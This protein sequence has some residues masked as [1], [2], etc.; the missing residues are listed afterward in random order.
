MKRILI[1]A[2]MAGSMLAAEAAYAASAT[3]DLAVS[4]E[5]TAFCEVKSG[6]TLTFTPT[7][8]W[9]NA[10]VDNTGSFNVQCTNGTPYQIGL[11]DGLHASGGVRRMNFGTEHLNYQLFTDSYG[12]TAWGNANG[13]TTKQSQTGDGDVQQHDVYGRVPSGQTAPTPGTYTDTVTITITY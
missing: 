12:G 3:G 11:N 13:S 4:M 9:W 5:V 7:G 8:A 6:G 2:M 1:P 10:N